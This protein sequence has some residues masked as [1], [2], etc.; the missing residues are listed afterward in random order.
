M[1]PLIT[2]TEVR[3]VDEAATEP[4]EAIIDRVGALV[5]MSAIDLLGGTYGR[6]VVVIAGPG[7]NGAD[8]RA[9]ATHLS[10]RGVKCTVVDVGATRLPVCDLVIDA[11]FGT[12]LS[13]EYEAPIVPSDVPVLSIDIPSGHDGLTGNPLGSPV[14]ATRTIVLDTLK[15]GLLFEPARSAAGDV[16]IIDIGLDATALITPSSYKVEGSDVAAWLPQRPPATHKWKAACWVVAGSPG[17]MGAAELAARGAQR[18]GATYVRLSTPASTRSN[19]AD[20]A[21]SIA[22]LVTQPMTASMETPDLERIASMVLGPGLGRAPELTRPLIDLIGRA[23]IPMV[24][25]ADAL[26]HLGHDRP[27][28]ETVLKHRK[29]PAV[30]TPH[31]GEFGRLIGSPPGADRISAAQS[32]ADRLSSVVLLKGATTVIAAPGHPALV[33]AEGDARLATAGTGDVLAGLIGALLAQGVDAQ[34][35][36][37]AGAFVHAKAAGRGPATGLVAGDLPDLLPEAWPTT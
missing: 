29:V 1:L 20:R 18:G 13:R 32:A 3:R 24:I 26:W 12:G 25:D 5:A 27:A 23:D 2:P 10:R 37:A 34:I 6:R 4:L 35:A 31:D 22:E 8:G 15:P 17:M 33:M 7:N 14:R 30:L 28:A 16:R 21:S 19:T 11:A 36:A 9:A